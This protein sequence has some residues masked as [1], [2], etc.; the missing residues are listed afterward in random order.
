MYHPI[1]LILKVSSPSFNDT[2]TMC[3]TVHVLEP[4][5]VHPYT[6]KEKQYLHH[7]RPP[8]P[9]LQSKC[10]ETSSTIPMG[11]TQ[12]TQ[13]RIGHSTMLEEPVHSTPSEETPTL[14]EETPTLSEQPPSSNIPVVVQEVPFI[15]SSVHRRI[16][17]GAY[18]GGVVGVSSALLYHLRYE[19]ATPDLLPVHILVLLITFKLLYAVRH[20]Q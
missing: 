3:K 4:S 7:P 17:F 9:P 8:T 14:S 16:C 19:L 11:H 10:D 6:P 1:K 13:E 2:Y 20:F 5:K 12:R 18:V 15:K